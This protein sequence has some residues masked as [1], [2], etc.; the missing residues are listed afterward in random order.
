MGEY[1]LK[2]QFCHDVDQRVV[3]QYVGDL[4]RGGHALICV[5]HRT[6]GTHPA[7]YRCLSLH[8]TL[9]NYMDN[10][11]T[12]QGGT[13]LDPITGAPGAHSVGVSLGP[14]GTVVG[15]T[16]GAAAGGLGGKAVAEHF[17]PTV[18]GWTA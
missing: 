15:A 17:D 12:R 8:G 6:D 13:N 14:V 5:R 16:V 1:C 9:E 18:E 4:H 10:D 7:R 11:N 3:A 2:C